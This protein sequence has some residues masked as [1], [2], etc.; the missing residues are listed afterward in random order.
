MAID[1]LPITGFEGAPVPNQFVRRGEP[2]NHL[3]ILLPGMGYTNGMPLLY[4][5]EQL[6][7]ENH[8]DVLRIDYNYRGV[9][10]ENELRQ[11]MAADL[12]A[13]IGAAL[14]E[15]PDYREFTLI[16]KSVGTLG[17]AFLL[18]NQL[19]PMETRCVWL[20]PLLTYEA[21]R[22][23][24]LLHP[25]PAFIAIGT[26]DPHYDSIWLTQWQGATRG[27]LA[28]VERGNHSLSI[29]HDVPRS[30]AALHDVMTKLQAFLTAS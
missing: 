5:G 1:T 25:E 12:S 28:I 17:M 26:A 3:A 10:D 19:V 11:R 30:I 23:R 18:E 27:T 9:G 29:P 20:T 7:L 16:G 21:L 14:T 13:A 4:Y 6:A 8:A 2:T 22:D 24:L 15:R